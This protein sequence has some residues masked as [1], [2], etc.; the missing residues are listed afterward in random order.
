MSVPIQTATVFISYS[1]QDD[2][3]ASQLIS[4]LR[5]RGISTWANAGFKPG[6]TWVD[7]SQKA[8]KESEIFVVSIRAHSEDSP[9]K[10]FELGAAVAAK[11]R[12]I[13]I[14][15]G[16]STQPPALPAILSKYPVL[17]NPSPLEA[18]QR[19]A[20]AVKKASKESRSN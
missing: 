5:E 17:I 8:L 4:N 19:V 7:Q 14:A 15:L 2:S 18:G 1:G 16:D 3:F 11:K 6:E 12:I 20:E 10:F 9:W 13:P